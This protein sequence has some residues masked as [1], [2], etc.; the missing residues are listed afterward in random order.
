MSGKILA[1]VVLLLVP[2]FAFADDIANQAGPF[3]MT[4]AGSGANN[5]SFRTGDFTLDGSFGVFILPVLEL[6]ARDGVS[7]ADAPHTHPVWGNTVDGAIDLNIPID[8]FEPY[9]GGNIGYACGTDA[10]STGE[11]AP[12]VGL[13]IFFTRSVFVFG[14]MEYDFFFNSTHSTFNNG[15]FVYSL[16]LGVRF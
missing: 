16:G 15:E 2:A 11:A 9:A 13:K 1:F 14:Q 6:S 3:E 8:R 12:E 10:H 5:D 4:I 7:Y